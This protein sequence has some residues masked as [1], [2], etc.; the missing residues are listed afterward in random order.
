MI[1][2][3]IKQSLVALLLLLVP[4]IAPERSGF[5]PSQLLGPAAIAMRSAIALWCAGSFTSPVLVVTL[6]KTLRQTNDLRIPFDRS[7]W[8]RGA[9]D[10]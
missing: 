3:T 2:R 1:L 4:A 5:A 10:G 9:T 8:T 6:A 7:F